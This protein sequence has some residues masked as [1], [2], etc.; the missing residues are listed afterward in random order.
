LKQICIMLCISYLCST[1]L[2]AMQQEEKQNPLQQ[3]LPVTQPPHNLVKDTQALSHNV[4]RLCAFSHI[5]KLAIVPVAIAA[6]FLLAYF[7]KIVMKY[8][9][10]AH[11]SPLIK[12]A[13]TTLQRTISLSTSNLLQLGFFAAGCMVFIY[14]T[15]NLCTQLV[16]IHQKLDAVE[17]QVGDRTVEISDFATNFS[18]ANEHLQHL[19]AIATPQLQAKLERV[20]EEFAHVAAE[21]QLWKGLIPPKQAPPGAAPPRR[22]S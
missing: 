12:Y 1:Q 10:P 13:A 14:Y 22:Q 21:L 7:T 20:K 9:P 17:R 11:V 4:S 15:I 8:K 6:C 16:T 3:L 5:K 19:Q 2:S 18:D